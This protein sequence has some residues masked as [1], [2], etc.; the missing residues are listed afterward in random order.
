MWELESQ[1]SN[2]AVIMSSLA[3][4]INVHSFLPPGSMEDAEQPQTV[5]EHHCTVF[6]LP[7]WC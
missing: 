1:S 6:G 3:L 7:R 4:S 2:T 5:C